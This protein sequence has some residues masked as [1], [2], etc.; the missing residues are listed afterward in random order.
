MHALQHFAQHPDTKACYRV[1]LSSHVR[2]SFV[3]ELG[4]NYG[5][6][7]KTLSIQG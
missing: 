7:L 3:F 2:L 4:F 6:P 5:D 1:G